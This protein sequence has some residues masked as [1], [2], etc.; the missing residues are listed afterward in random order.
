[1][2]HEL[3]KPLGV[4]LLGMQAPAQ[5]QSHHARGIVRLIVAEG[6]YDLRNSGGDGGG[7]GADAAVVRQ[8]AA[9]VQY[10]RKWDEAAVVDA[11]RQFR[12][13]LLGVIG[14]EQGGA[15]QILAGIGGGTEKGV[16]EN[17]A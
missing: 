3:A 14:Q 12:G 1:V 11:G 6:H 8:T 17:I 7:G 10:P 5:M 15:A 16:A 13:Q 2:R 9:Q 4:E